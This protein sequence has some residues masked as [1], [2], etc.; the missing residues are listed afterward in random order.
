[1]LKDYE[2]V[3][4]DFWKDLVEVDGKIDFD[5][6]KKELYDFHRLIQ[7]IP[8][9]FEHVTGGACTKPLT[10]VEVVCSL[11]DEYYA[12]LHGEQE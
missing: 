5:Q 12:E 7:N 1:M 2:Q 4:E 11:A 9:I 8:R 6:I 10:N 3:Y